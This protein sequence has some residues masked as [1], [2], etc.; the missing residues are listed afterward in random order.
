MRTI[1][2]LPL[3]CDHKQ[4]QPFFSSSDL[5]PFLLE[6]SQGVL[7]EILFRRPDSE[8]YHNLGITIVFCGAVALSTNQ[9]RVFWA[10]APLLCDCS[11]PRLNCGNDALRSASLKTLVEN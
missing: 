10:A 2:N 1:T 5:T 6:P 7:L 4:S 11:A 9:S 3:L 8:I